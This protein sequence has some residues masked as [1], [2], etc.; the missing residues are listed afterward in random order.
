MRIRPAPAPAPASPLWERLRRWFGL[1]PPPARAARERRPAPPPPPRASPPAPRVGTPL[2]APWAGLVAAPGVDA[3]A[4]RAHVIRALRA[5][6]ATEPALADAVLAVA[7]DERLDLPVFPD[8]ARAL[9]RLLRAGDP[10]TTEVARLLQQDPDLVR[11]VWQAANGAGWARAAASLDHAL[12]RI[13]MDETWRIAMGACVHAPVF[14]LRAFQAQADRARARGLVAA[15][16]AAHLAAEGRGD[17]W[18]AGLVHEAGPL[19]VWRAAARAQPVPAA[20]AVEA[21]LREIGPS[22]SVLV[23]HA[24]GLGRT[25][26]WGAGLHPDPAAASPEGRRIA[27]T[28]QVARMCAVAVLEAEEGRDWGVLGALAEAADPG[29]DPPSALR[30]ARDTLGRLRAGAAAAG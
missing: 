17:A 11:R 6:Q 10:P 21:L 29:V 8:V 25:V 16:V 24:W 3:G 30:V 27:R 15:E 14:R 19:V 26:A 5:L 2:E 28:V 18:V 9:D 20:G 7:G 4:A 1:G 12:A 13:G 22:M 23:A